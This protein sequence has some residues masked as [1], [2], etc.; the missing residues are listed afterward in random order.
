MEEALLVATREL[1]HLLSRLRP[2]PSWPAAAPSPGQ[3]AASPAAGLQSRGASPDSLSSNS[4]SEGEL[5]FEEVAWQPGSP[6]C[7][8]VGSSS[9]QDPVALVEEA[10][11]ALRAAKEWLAAHGAD[12]V[13]EPRPVKED[14]ACSSGGASCSA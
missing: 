7:C 12:A 8:A 3:S 14:G 1:S 2:L 5:F 4:A 6:A 9:G 11:A 10:E 13:P